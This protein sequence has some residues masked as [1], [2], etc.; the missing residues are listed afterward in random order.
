MTTTVLADCACCGLEF[1]CYAG[2]FARKRCAACRMGCAA[3]GECRQTFRICGE[4]Q[5][6]VPYNANWFE[7]A[8]YKGLKH[9]R[10]MGLCEGCFR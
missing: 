7:V 1:N 8:A 3:N 10:T 5:N 9:I 6:R 2:Q 4:C